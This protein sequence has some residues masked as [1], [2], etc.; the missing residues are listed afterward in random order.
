[1]IAA[2]GF[3]PGGYDGY[4]NR[5]DGL[6]YSG[7]SP[8][9][10]LGGISEGE[11]AFAL[12]A[13]F[14]QGELDTL[15]AMGATDAEIDSLI[16]GEVDV[17]TLMA[18]LSGTQ[19]T[20]P[21]TAAKMQYEPT[22]WASYGVESALASLGA[23]LDQLSA[24][25]NAST[26]VAS[27]IGGPLGAALDQ[28]ATWQ[29]E[30][31]GWVN[32][33]PHPQILTMPDGSQHIVSVSEAGVNPYVIVAVGSVTALAAAILY[34][35]QVTVAGLISQAKAIMSGNMMG[36]AAVDQAGALDQSA[37]SDDAQ[38][39]AIV[40]SNPAK[41]ASLHQSASQ[42]RAQASQ[43]L[44]TARQVASAAAGGGAAPQPPPMDW[45]AWFQKNAIWIVV[46]GGA[47]FLGPSL[48]KKI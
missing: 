28:Y 2:V 25:T 47:I 39:N 12:S 10:G 48:I 8:S 16:Q 9:Y 23:D 35:H 26:A 38:A 36:T 32:S 24:W 18:R 29:A 6:G 42:K 3:M 46:G 1:M 34:Y 30:Y 40:A 15:D 27:A 13:G 20:Q 33:G 43:I 21:I 31:Q 22:D 4:H 7:G 5:L 11:Y 17:P 44:T 37:S 45:G 19:P 41:A 14:G